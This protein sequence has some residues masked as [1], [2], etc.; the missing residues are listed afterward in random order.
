MKTTCLMVLI[1]CS[2]A[3]MPG[4]SS[5]VPPHQASQQTARGSAANTASNH[6]Q[7]SEHST[8]IGKLS[9]GRQG[10]SQKVPGKTAPRRPATRTKVRPK[11]LPN[12]RERFA[13]GNNTNLLRPDSVNSRGAA[14]GRPN[15]Q[16][17]LRSSTLVRAPKASQPSLNSL[18]HRGANPASVA[19]AANSGARNA[20][21]IDGTSV[22]RRP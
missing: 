4:V 10:N 8:P 17:T 6:G 2:A 14:N 5:A 9:G 1:I 19:G 22:H 21:A 12:N 13:P 3:F 15:Q 18:R 7:V 16:A 11:E 20:G